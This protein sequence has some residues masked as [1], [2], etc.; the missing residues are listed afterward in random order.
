MTNNT[1]IIQRV[2]ERLFDTSE[3]QSDF[4]WSGVI[5]YYRR[6]LPFR[7]Y[8]LFPI[9]PLPPPAIKP[10]STLKL[11]RGKWDLQEVVANDGTSQ[12]REFI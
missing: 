1:T 9:L 2:R 8:P 7:S 3:F 11:A 4:Q 5:Y 12:E 6:Y 10:T